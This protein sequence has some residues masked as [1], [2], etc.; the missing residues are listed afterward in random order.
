[1]ER[2]AWR[3]ALAVAP[4]AAER[5]RKGAEQER[6]RVTVFREESGA[7]GLSGRDLPAG[8]ALSGHANV[9]ARA[10]HYEAS[11]AFGGETSR[12]LEALAYIHLLNGVT[13]QDAIAFAR[14]AT[15]GP[16]A[17]PNRTAPGA[18]VTI[19][20][21]KTTAGLAVRNPTAAQGR[22][23]STAVVRAELTASRCCPR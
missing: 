19:T 12:T 11:G 23:A 14:T 17:A 8:H 22:A 9:L 3:A 6:A 20:G 13:A 5:R 2:L 1:M 4:D 16:P 15:A 10:R 18:P 7:V 21:Q